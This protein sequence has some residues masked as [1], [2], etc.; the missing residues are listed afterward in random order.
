MENEVIDCS[1]SVPNLSR[2]SFKAKSIYGYWL[3]AWL[4]HD[5]DGQWSLFWKCPAENMNKEVDPYTLCH[6]TGLKDSR[7]NYIYENDIIQLDNEERAEFV[8]CWNSDDLTYEVDGKNG[9]LCGL[10][11]IKYWIEHGYT[12]VIIGNKFDEESKDENV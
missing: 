5:F 4:D 8:V 12:V 6:C 1:K 11:F 9:G 2:F 7:G 10:A 3:Y